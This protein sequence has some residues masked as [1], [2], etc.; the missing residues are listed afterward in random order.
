MA[1]A[2]NGSFIPSTMTTADP[3]TITVNRT[4]QVGDV[5]VLFISHASTSVAITAVTD[6]AGNDWDVHSIS[7]ASGLVAIAV[8]TVGTVLTSGVSTVSVN[9]ASAVRCIVRGASYEGVTS[10]WSSSATKSTTGSNYSIS[11][12]ADEEGVAFVAFEFPND[13]VFADD[14]ISGWTQVFVTDDLTGLHSQQV[15]RDEVAAGVVTASN[16]A[17]SLPYL[18]VGL[19]LP[20]TRPGGYGQAVIVL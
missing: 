12:T 14:D 16:S 4:V 8:A 13:Y 1:F 10:T 11:W 5:A 6:S 7:N 17:P 15:F 3:I 19:V 9:L 20:Y 18:A 2:S